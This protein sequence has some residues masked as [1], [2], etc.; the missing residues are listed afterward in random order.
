MRRNAAACKIARETLAFLNAFEARAQANIDTRKA[1]FAEGAGIVPPESET[2]WMRQASNLVRAQTLCLLAACL[3]LG[4]CHPDLSGS[5]PTVKFDSVPKADVSGY[6]KLDAIQGHVAGFKPG[7]QIVLYTNSEELWW[8]QPDIEHP[9]TKIQGKAGWKAQV[10]LG[11]QYAALLVDPGY[12]PPETFEALPPQDNGVAAVSVVDGQ[13]YTP[14]PRATNI[15]HFSGYDW[16][17]RTAASNRAGTRNSFDAANAWTDEHGDLH[18]RIA[19]RNGKWTC[20]EVKLTRSLGY[21][22]YTF[23]VGDTSHFEPSVILTLLTWDGLGSERNR[24]ELD[25]EIGRWGYPENGNAHYVVQPYFIP[26]NFV[27]FRVPGGV[28]THSFKWEPSQVTFSTTTGSQDP[29][30]RL[31]NRHVFTSGIPPAGGDSVRINLYVFNKGQI[32]LQHETEVVIKKFE[33][34]P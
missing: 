3:V 13:G 28:L 15:L 11:T 33:F 29:G 23:V 2:S 5:A 17:V 34:L 19:R 32:P 12:N 24:R 9:F 6:D 26:A 30:G 27:R 10:H 4:A 20:A 7:Q 1:R 18:L 16:A 25:V 14:V 31:I 22:T 21:G 8:I